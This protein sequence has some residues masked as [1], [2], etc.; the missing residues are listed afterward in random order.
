TGRPPFKAATIWETL[1]LVRTADPVPPRQLQPS[2]P[3][4]LETICLQCLRKDPKRRYATALE[5]A[6]DL[7]RFGRGE[8]VRARAIGPVERTARWVK[9]RPVVAGLLALLVLTVAGFSTVL[10]ERNSQLGT[11]N[12]ELEGAN[13]KIKQERDNAKTEETR[14]R[15]AE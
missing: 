8:P 10:I 14:A 5:L 3:R 2:V 12:T 1:D 9:R 6:D 4:D 15:T 13:T 11:A 7:A